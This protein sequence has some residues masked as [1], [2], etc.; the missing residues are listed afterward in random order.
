MR[1]L[2]FVHVTESDGH[3]RR[4]RR[5]HEQTARQSGRVQSVS[6]RIQ[7][8]TRVSWLLVIGTD[9]SIAIAVPLHCFQQLGFGLS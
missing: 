1:L 5:S 8:H 2:W 6:W 4:T 3:P 9:F 7:D